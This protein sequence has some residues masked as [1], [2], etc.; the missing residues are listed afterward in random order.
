VPLTVIDA[1]ANRPLVQWTGPGGDSLRFGH[2]A[3][4]LTD[5]LAGTLI[6]INPQIAARP[7]GR[8]Q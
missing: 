7:P 4:W 8:R 3:I 5:Y 1:Q 6:R 2:G